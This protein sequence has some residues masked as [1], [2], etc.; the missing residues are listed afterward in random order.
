MCLFLLLLFFRRGNPLKLDPDQ[1]KEVNL[2]WLNHG[3]PEAIVAETE[4][5]HHFLQHHMVAY[6]VQM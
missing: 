4:I 2:L 5:H 6:V 1:M 3:I